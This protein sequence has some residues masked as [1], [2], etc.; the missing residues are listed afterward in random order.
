MESRVKNAKRNIFS[1]VINKV[2]SILMPF[3]IRTIIINE[4]GIEYLG[5]D[6]L[7]VSILQILN[8]SEMGISSAIVYCLYKPIS[9]GD[10]EKI[11]ALYNFIRKA[12]HYI[13]LGILLVG[14]IIVPFLR[15]FIAG[16]IPEDVNLYLLYFIYLFNTVIS[17]FL[18][19]YKNALLNAYQRIDISTNILTIS[20]MLM[21][22]L[23]IVLLIIFQN[24]YIYAIMLPLCT[25]INN[26]ITKYYTDKLFPDIVA[27]GNLEE[28]TKDKLKKQIGG[29]FVTKICTVS[30]NSLDSIVISAYLG[31]SVTAIYGNY[32]Y[33][34]SGVLALLV[35]LTSSIIPSIGNSIATN[36]VEKN[37]KDFIKFNFMYM[38]IAGIC[39]V[40]LYN[41]Y[42]PFMKMWVGKDMMFDNTI[43]V[44]F[45]I[46]FYSL[47]IGSVR[48]AYAE[49]AGLWWENRYKSILE[50]VLNIVLNIILGKFFGVVG[51]LA[52][53]ILTV[54]FINYGFSAQIL[55]K[56]Y[57]KNYKISDYFV[58]T[59]F[60]SIVIFVVCVITYYINNHIMLDGIIGIILKVI[61]AFII[62]NFIFW[63]C[64]RKL[65]E[66]ATTVSWVKK[67][68]TKGGNT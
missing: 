47:T 23:Q 14:L 52:A 63:I 49:A 26:Y 61:I 67:I 31:L 54:V 45:T 41:A 5:L 62:S 15:Y 4:L 44:L 21:Y 24:Y 16:S 65:T 18:F 13:G 34:L 11:Y 6:N 27:K 38:W 50:A 51:I 42:Q 43:V 7:F 17:Y 2:F 29:V 30:R 22:I 60:Y 58:K 36:T 25:I 10:N 9:E 55:Y 59:L 33:I 66:Y 64:F 19:A 46:Y 56:M 28:E 37:Y 12:Y 32:Y 68:L 39:T 8:L 57:F 3:V 48:A 53:T 1:S 35:I 20:R 40:C